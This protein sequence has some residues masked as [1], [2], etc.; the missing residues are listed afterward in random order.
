MVANVGDLASS[1]ERVGLIVSEK[2]KSPV[3]CM[4]GNQELLMRTSTTIGA[5]EDRCSLAGGRAGAGDRL[6]LQVSAR[7]HPR[8]AGRRSGTM[9][10]HAAPQVSDAPRPVARR[11]HHPDSQG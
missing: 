4:F 3:R 11:S 8:R 10:G 2:Y 9:L 5:A 7:R 6:Q 1:V